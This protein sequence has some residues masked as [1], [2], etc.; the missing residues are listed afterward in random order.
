MNNMKKK[1]VEKPKVVEAWTGPGRKDEKITLFKPEYDAIHIDMNK[2]GNTEWWYFD[3]ILDNGYIVDD[4]K[5]DV[6]NIVVHG[7]TSNVFGWLLLLMLRFICN[8]QCICN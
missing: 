7:V 5:Y 4:C 1:N 3:A 6:T 2:R 8:V